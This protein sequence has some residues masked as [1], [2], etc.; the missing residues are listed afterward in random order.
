M[1]ITTAISGF[2]VMADVCYIL[3]MVLVI[4]T[5]DNNDGQ[6]GS[7]GFLDQGLEFQQLIGLMVI[8]VIWCVIWFLI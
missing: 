4:G 1:L 6:G 7:P 8:P 3:E 5:N 2:T